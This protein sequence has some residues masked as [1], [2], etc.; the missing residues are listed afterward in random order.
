MRSLGCNFR[1]LTGVINW[2]VAVPMPE[3]ILQNEVYQIVGA[4][5]EV[6]NQLGTGFLE[7]VYQEAL[8][9]ELRKRTIPFEAQC[10]LA[11]NY[12]GGT[13]EKEVRRRPHLFQRDYRRVE[14][15]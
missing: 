10:D 11:I 9:L 13:T 2:Q 1:Y 5:I 6:Y 12:K 3:L 14:G 4:A 7:P 15:L 8:E